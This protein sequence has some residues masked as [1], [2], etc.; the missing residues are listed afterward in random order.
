MEKIREA[1]IQS[2]RICKLLDLLGDNRTH[3]PLATRC[4]GIFTPPLD[5]S[6]EAEALRSELRS[7]MNDLEEIL[8]NDFRIVPKPQDHS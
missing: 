1:R 7:A 4:A 3:R 5:A 6:P 8:A 2:D